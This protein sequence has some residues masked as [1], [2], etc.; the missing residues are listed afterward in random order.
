MRG[1]EWPGRETTSA[2]LVSKFWHDVRTEVSFSERHR[3]LP[4]TGFF[5]VGQNPCKTE[6]PDFIWKHFPCKLSQ[7]KQIVLLVSDLKPAEVS[8]GLSVPCRE[9]VCVPALCWKG[10]A[11][12]PCLWVPVQVCTCCGRAGPS[13]EEESTYLCLLSCRGTSFNMSP[14]LTG[15]SWPEF[16]HTK[17]STLHVFKL[18]LLFNQHLSTA[19]VLFYSF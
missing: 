16:K 6:R 1:R 18:F 12:S 3:I 17:W 10:S 2:M 4:S 5:Y 14:T 13:I 9:L 19:P 15:F 8:D 7:L 11:G